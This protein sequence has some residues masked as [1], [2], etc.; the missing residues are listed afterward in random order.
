ML[1]ALY[2]KTRVGICKENLELLE[3]GGDDFLGR[4]VTGDETWVHCYDSETK[5]QSMQWKHKGSPP[6]KKFKVKPSAGKVMAT[7]F[8]DRE[9]I[10]LIEY[11][12]NKK[13]MS[14]EAYAS[15][16]LNLREAI[17]EKRRGLMASGVLLLH[18]NAPVHKCVKAA[19]AI[20]DCGF[21][22]LN[23]PPY[24]LDMTPSDFYLFRNLKS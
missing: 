5:Q 16:L 8:C 2:K 23:H 17:K 22:E 10:L 18:D 14:G 19:S 7:V 12:E 1:T 4:I 3:E 11:M 15:T 6:P 21:L 20:K 13:T 24:S 9:G